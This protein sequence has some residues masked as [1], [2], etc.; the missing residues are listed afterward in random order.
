MRYCRDACPYYLVS[1]KTLQINLKTSSVISV[2]S[3]DET[4]MTPSQRGRLS[5]CNR[6]VF[7]SETISKTNDYSRFHVGS[8]IKVAFPL[9]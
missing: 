4:E 8:E 7:A 2:P 3:L 1:T 9:G 5:S 6:V